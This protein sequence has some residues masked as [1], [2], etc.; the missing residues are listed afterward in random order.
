LRC[1]RTCRATYRRHGTVARNDAAGR[2]RHAGTLFTAEQR[3][4]VGVE[5]ASMAPREPI[6]ASLHAAVQPHAGEVALLALACAA[7]AVCRRESRRVRVH[8]PLRWAGDLTRALLREATI[9]QRR[10]TTSWCGTAA[11]GRW[12]SCRPIGFGLS[13]DRRQRLWLPANAGRRGIP[14]H[15]C[16][17]LGLSVLSRG[18]DGRHQDQQSDQ[19]ITQPRHPHA[20]VETL[21]YRSRAECQC[22]I[23]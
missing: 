8:A 2:S 14:R 6:S 4:L 10:C 15:G 7:S 23:A 3:S 19:P 20:G 1:C 5:H 16:K 21:S 22:S 18:C 9:R 13:L 17:R 11:W 12:W